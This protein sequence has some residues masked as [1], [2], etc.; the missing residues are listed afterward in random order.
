M[1]VEGRGIADNNQIDF[2]ALQITSYA[3][4]ELVKKADV[5]ES[6]VNHCS[7]GSCGFKEG[8]AGGGNFRATYADK[9]DV[10][11][12]LFQSCYESCAMG[13]GAWLGGAYEDAIGLFCFWHSSSATG[14]Q[15]YYRDLAGSGKSLVWRILGDF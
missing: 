7:A 13:V 8:A 12:A 10:I 6:V 4:Y 1:K 15:G 14:G 5:A 11:S 9:V 2:I 3:L